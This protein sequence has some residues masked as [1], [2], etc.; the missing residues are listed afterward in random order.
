MIY[1]Y[2]LY[3]DDDLKW[4]INLMKINQ[5]IKESNDYSTLARTIHNKS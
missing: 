1:I 5:S 2:I 3:Y 4:I